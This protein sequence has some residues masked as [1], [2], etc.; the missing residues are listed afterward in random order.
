VSQSSQR[1]LMRLAG[2]MLGVGVAVAVLVASRPG[3]AGS[4]LPASVH[5]AVAPAGELEVTPSPPRP[6]FANDALLPGGRHAV[7]SFQV[8]NQTGTG[9]AIGLW[10][11]ANSSAFN[12][13]LRVRVL[14]GGRPLADTT[15]E[16][17]QRRP[18]RLDL[19]SGQRSDLR[20]EAWLPRDILS[21][22]EGRLVNVSLVPRV[23]VLGGHR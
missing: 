3:A 23:Q 19:A 14:S 21:G 8:R 7:G 10:A 6:V 9:L 4:P 20:L 2:A 18:V 1:N 16:G 5:V 12:G 15:L 13:L 11:H 17:L 22:Y